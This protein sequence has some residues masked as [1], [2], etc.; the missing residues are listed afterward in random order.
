MLRDHFC[1]V[2]NPHKFCF[3]LLNTMVVV[4]TK[5]LCLSLF[6]IFAMLVRPQKDHKYRFYWN[7]YHHGVGY[8]IVVLGIINVFKGLDILRPGDKYRS[9]YVFLL[10]SIGVVVLVLEIFT[11]VIVMKRKSQNKSTKPYDG[12]NNGESRQEPLAL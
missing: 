11:W 6:Q 12:Y 8:A 7:I 1:M 3:V 5:W 9:A 2:L 10:V 4:L